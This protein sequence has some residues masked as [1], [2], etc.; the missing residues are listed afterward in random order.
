MALRTQTTKE[1]MK[2]PVGLS[3]SGEKGYEALEYLNESRIFGYN[4]STLVVEL[5]LILKDAES[6]YGYKA[7]EELKKFANSGK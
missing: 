7:V 2:R 4:K 3:F 5:I 1:T 6:L